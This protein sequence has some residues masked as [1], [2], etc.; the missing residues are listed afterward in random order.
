M[1]ENDFEVK[2]YRNEGLLNQIRDG[3]GLYK[4]DTVE[5]YLSQ[6][7]Q[8]ILEEEDFTIEDMYTRY[9]LEPTGL[10]EFPDR[11]KFRFELIQEEL[12][13]YILNISLENSPNSR[14]R[15]DYFF[16]INPAKFPDECLQINNRFLSAIYIQKFLSRQGIYN[17]CFKEQLFNE[18]LIDWGI[19]ELIENTSRLDLY[20]YIHV[21]GVTSFHFRYSEFFDEDTMKIFQNYL[22]Q[23]IKNIYMKYPLQ[24]IKRNNTYIKYLIKDLIDSDWFLDMDIED[25]FLEDIELQEKLVYLDGLT[26]SRKNYKSSDIFVENI[27][28]FEDSLYEVQR[29]LIENG[30]SDI[31][32]SLEDL[33]SDRCNENISLLKQKYYSLE[34][35]YGEDYGVY[36]TDVIYESFSI[37][38]RYTKTV[39]SPLI[40]S[41]LQEIGDIN[42]SKD[43]REVV[44]SYIFLKNLIQWYGGSISGRM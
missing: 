44:E 31:F 33:L 17:N 26:K 27:P 25:R 6:I 35:F 11:L 7:S 15:F 23:G 42:S 16:N 38:Y 12:S 32:V 13:K 2:V 14:E 30:L 18:C 5:Y 8:G 22:Y 40:R 4:E 34:K 36:I 28:G 9:L 43:V 20:D 24:E 21:L 19:K 10:E 37:E 41:L 29:S 1:E 39:F 3:Y